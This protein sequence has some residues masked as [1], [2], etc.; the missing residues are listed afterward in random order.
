MK[1]L[2]RILYKLGYVSKA[3]MW[4]GVNDLHKEYRQKLRDAE[5]YNLNIL[6]SAINSVN[7]VKVRTMFPGGVVWFEDGDPSKPI[8]YEM[9]TP[10]DLNWYRFTAQIDTAKLHRIYTELTMAENSMEFDY[11]IKSVLHKIE[12]DIRVLIKVAGIR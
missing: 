5:N 12:H 1:L 8:K 7:M 10:P 4:S 6:I 3:Y 9:L 11:L 2:D